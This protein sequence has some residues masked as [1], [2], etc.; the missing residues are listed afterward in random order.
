MLSRAKIDWKV[1]NVL[2]QSAV[3]SL[4][5]HFV[6]C[7]CVCACLW[8]HMSKRDAFLVGIKRGQ[9]K[10][11]YYLNGSAV[12]LPSI[13]WFL[14]NHCVNLCHFNLLKNDHVKEWSVQVSCI[15]RCTNS[16]CKVVECYWDCLLAISWNYVPLCSVLF[17]LCEYNQSMLHLFHIDKF[18]SGIEWFFLFSFRMRQEHRCFKNMSLFLCVGVNNCLV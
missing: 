15:R 17:N 14:C 2:S 8:H 16:S 12:E 3:H 11:H 9:I 1:L 10:L 7:V 13:M 18:T 4:S 5:H 6:Y